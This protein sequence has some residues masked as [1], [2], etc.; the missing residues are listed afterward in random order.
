MDGGQRAY[1]IARMTS[2]AGWK[3]RSPSRG[4]QTAGLSALRHDAAAAAMSD[5][6]RLCLVTGSRAQPTERVS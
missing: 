1:R 4:G 2:T 3:A 5:L 6:Q